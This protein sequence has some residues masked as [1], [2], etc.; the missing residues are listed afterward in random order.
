MTTVRAR[1]ENIL[2]DCLLGL[3]AQGLL[4]ELPPGVAAVS[5]CKDPKHGDYASNAAMILSKAARKKPQE[6]A[7]MIRDQ[8]GGSDLV[9]SAEVAGPGFLNIRLK[10]SVWHGVIPQIL[11]HGGTWGRSI[12]QP[13][14]V[15]VEFTSAN[16]TGPLHVAHGRGTVLGDAICRMLRAAGDE[17]T[18]EF[19]VNDYGNQVLT[20]GRSVYLRYRELL[21]ETVELPKDAYPAEYV[22]DI[23]RKVHAE[24]GDGLMNAPEST[25]LPLC[26]DVGIRFNLEWIK[27]DLR[28]FNVM[29]ERF[30]S[31]KALHES[32]AVTR[33]AEELKARGMT[34]EASAAENTGDKKRREDSKAAQHADEQ[35]GGTFLR[36]GR[37]G[38]EEDRVILRRD[39]TPVYLLADLCYHGRKY[40]RGY[41]RIIDVWGAD[42]GGHVTRMRAGL[43]AM[44]LDDKRLEIPLV[45][46]VRL[47]RN[48]QEVRIS[49][50]TGNLLLLSE[51]I[52]EIGPDAARY[53]FLM[54][55][56]NT[57]LDVDL[58]KAREQSLNNPVFYAQYGHARTCAIFR[59]ALEKG[60]SFT[61]ATPEAVAALTL[62]EEISL[63]RRLA[64]FPDKLRDAARALEPHRMVY[65]L[66]DLNA[67]FHSYY[68]RYSRTD[69]VI[70][71]D[72]LKT[73]GRLALVQALQ[74]TMARTLGILG[75]SAPERMEL[76]EQEEN[77]E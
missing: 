31:E 30:E 76:A 21:G 10:P 8:L 66:N 23:A 7:G 75:V 18:S 74:I 37:F 12:E 4:P 44:G 64:A 42:H 40:H 53:Y 27:R 33:L 48:G 49:K 72:P 3:H 55:S 57:Q 22:K 69:R 26:T 54:R 73:Q 45:Q 17:V 14:K 50:R 29:H 39:G 67:E 70:S 6:L 62:P 38:D 1:V 5:P 60:I 61:G 34:Y 32:G 65:E 36:T 51:L 77:A 9:E 59:K 63:L 41:D 13:Q 68:T 43:Q 19:Y 46:M 25:W 47:M 58:D 20:L 35:Q 56:P 52:D 16:P 28:A 2:Q 71:D 24:H 11:E 15:L